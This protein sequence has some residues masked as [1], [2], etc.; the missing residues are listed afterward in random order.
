[1]NPATALS[2]E[3]AKV[4]LASILPTQLAGDAGEERP[5]P[6]GE[7]DGSSFVQ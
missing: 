4:P 2:R 1:M 6:A 5:R 7:E 3:R